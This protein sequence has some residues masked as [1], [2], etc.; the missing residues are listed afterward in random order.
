MYT[1]GFGEVL[2]DI[3]TIN[4]FIRTIPSASAILDTSNFTF[5]AVTFG[6]DANG[7]NYHGHTI[8]TSSAGLVNS[9]ILVATSYASP[10][11]SS[12]YFSAT[13][14]QFSSTYSSIPNY[15]SIYDRRL[16]RNSTDT[17]FISSAIV[18]SWNPSDLGHYLNPAIDS[19]YSS[20]WN[21]IGG[22]PPGGN[23]S[24]YMLRDT[25]GNIIISGT[26][27]GVYNEYGLV[28]KNG[29]ITI[30]PSAA[31]SSTVNIQDI[32]QGPTLLSTTIQQP[33]EFGLVIVPMYGDGAALALFGG[34]THLGVWCLD[35][36]RM[37]SEGLTPPYSWNNLNNTRKYKLVAKYS[38]WDNLMT[39]DD[40]IVAA[41]TFSGLES[42]LNL[43]FGIIPGPQFSVFFNLQ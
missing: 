25:S 14:N 8:E 7:F 31:K 11:V 23:S 32:L 22:Y 34:I 40:F 6:K 36:K 29:F 13:Y 10:S 20:V 33:G 1:V 27:S 9:G 21:V 30:N 16:E 41:D 35:I 42:A 12:Y 2:A 3:M 5:A 24:T 18:G 28:D 43:G 19:N 17:N 38:F 4:P 26:L 37:L 15:P 39:H